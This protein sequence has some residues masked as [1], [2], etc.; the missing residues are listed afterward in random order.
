MMQSPAV[1]LCLTCDWVHVTVSPIPYPIPP[2]QVYVYKQSGAGAS[3]YTQTK[4]SASI[5]T[6]LQPS[7]FSLDPIQAITLSRNTHLFARSQSNTS[8]LYWSWNNGSDWSG[9]VAIGDSSDYLAYD[10]Y[11]A[12][13]SLV[14]R[15]E[16]YGVFQSGYLL[17]TWQNSQTSFSDNWHKLGGLFSPKFNSAPVVHQMGQSFFNGMLVAFVRGEDGVVHRIQQTTCDKVK[18]PWGPC[19][20][21]L[22]FSKLG[23]APPSDKSSR[24][25][26]IASR[27]IHLGIEASGFPAQTFIDK[28]QNLAV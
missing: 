12:V 2:F 19:T 8:R 18:N 24:N 3:S 26:F 28:A 27:N 15:L 9:W 23:G 4:L 17:H 11:V 7:S 16:V 14:D 13:N 5:P 21:D 25:P 1:D 22:F 10:P 6:T 20:W